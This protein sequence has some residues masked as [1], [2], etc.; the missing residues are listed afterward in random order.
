MGSVAGQRYWSTVL[1]Q[2]STITTGTWTPDDQQASPFPISSFLKRAIYKFIIFICNTLCPL[3]LVLCAS[4]KSFWLLI[5]RFIWALPMEQLWFWTFTTELWW[6]RS[7]WVNA[8]VQGPVYCLLLQ[9]HQSITVSVNWHGTVRASK[10]RNQ[11]RQATTNN[12][13]M[14]LLAIPSPH[15]VHSRFFLL[16]KIVG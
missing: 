6:L 1:T 14:R 13:Q 12:I 11:R 16:I 9:Q 7:K 2:E 15:Q 3:V 4:M 8:P 5:D 10:W